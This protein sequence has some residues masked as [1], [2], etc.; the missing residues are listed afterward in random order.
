MMKKLDNT[1]YFK[2]QSD[3]EVRSSS[4]SISG[5]DREGL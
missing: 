2:I 3:Q 1:Q 4:V 5:Y